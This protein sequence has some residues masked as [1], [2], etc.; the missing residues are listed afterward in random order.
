MR[1]VV[2]KKFEQL[3]NE[4]TVEKILN[5][6]VGDKVEIYSSVLGGTYFKNYTSTVKDID[7]NFITID[8]EFSSRFYTKDQIGH[9]VRKKTSTNQNQLDII[10]AV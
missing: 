6:N 4:N 8:D 7:E 10:F 9:E 3:I 2:L 1:K 5:V